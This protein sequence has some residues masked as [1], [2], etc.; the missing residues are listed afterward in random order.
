[1]GK[2]PKSTYFIP[3]VVIFFICQKY[4]KLQTSAKK[5]KMTKFFAKKYEKLLSF[6][7]KTFDFH[8]KWKKKKNAK[9][10]K[11]YYY[12]CQKYENY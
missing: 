7:P 11:N 6:L 8:E 4:E 3:S 1:M 12:F 5:K 2:V 9:N 10:T